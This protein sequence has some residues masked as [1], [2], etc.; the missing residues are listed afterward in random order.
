MS[1]PPLDVIEELFEQARRLPV[2]EQAAFVSA[3]SE[4]AA[5]RT[6]LSS[7][8]E[9]AEEAGPFLEGLAIHLRAAAALEDDEATSHVAPTSDLEPARLVNQYR[10]EELLGAGGMGVVYRAVDTRLGREV[11]L[12]FLPP[13]MSANERARRRLLAEARAA[14]ALNH[15]NVCALHEIG[16]DP[17][18]HVYIAMGYYGGRTLDRVL[19]EGPTSIDQ[20][21]RWAREVASALVAAHGR[22]IVHRDIKPGNILITGEDTV[23]LLDFGLAK[24]GDATVTDVGARL[25]TVAYMSPEQTR[26]EKVREETDLWSLGV[27]LYEMLTG[28]RPFDGGNAAV[29]L[30]AIRDGRPAPPS[31]LRDDLPADLEELVSGLLSPDPAARRRPFRA[32]LGEPEGVDGDVAASRAG[33]WRR[34]AL[35][36]GAAMALIAGGAYLLRRPAGPDLPEIRR[37]AVLPLA[38][39]THAPEQHYVVEGL[40]QAVLETL[41]R[42]RA[43]TVSSTDAVERYR[44]GARPPAEIARELGVDAVVEG[45][46]RMSGDSLRVEI[47]LLRAEDGARVWTGSFGGS[48]RGDILAL[49]SRVVAGIMAVTGAEG[50]AP[51]R[52]GAAG[53]EPRAERAYL[54]GLYEL[55]LHKN[56][57]PSDPTERNR[58]ARAALADFQEAVRIEPG[59]AAA[60]AQLASAYGW[61]ASG[62]PGSDSSFYWDS[63]KVE[64]TWALSLDESE[65]DAFSGLGFVLFNHEHDWV[66][67]ERAIVRAIELEPSSEHHWSYGLYLEAVGRYAESV[68]QY[69]EAEERDPMSRGLEGQVAHAYLC[70]GRYEE[71][72]RRY[73]Q[74]LQEYMRPAEAR[75]WLAYTYSRAGRHQEAID[76][77]QTAIALSDSAALDVA[78]L[79]YV[80]ARAGEVGKARAL[81]RWLDETDA[82]WDL[83]AFDAAAALAAVGEHERAV[84]AYQ[85]GIEQSWAASLYMRC[86][87]SYPELRDDPRIRRIEQGMHFPGGSSPLGQH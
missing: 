44:D 45:S 41:T 78:G 37:L 69:E 17:A 22:G 32:L 7:L 85:R 26:G 5:V 38:D 12:K 62:I 30:E 42:S 61:L 15:P 27:V 13:H 77:L 46:V 3:C 39:S 50:A 72:I 83:E 52:P 29:V 24:L 64:A 55:R 59:W 21:M 87:W 63:A 49:P 86:G 11:A 33:S 84:A 23:R 31:T 54:Q 53:R 28:R 40:H 67:A 14:A 66:Q 10:I 47:R 80:R 35:V 57:D 2:A 4:N 18:G 70:A 43:V 75:L 71:A 9:A 60:H 76:L 73:R 58:H 51:P 65:A 36:G 82:G 25:G 68:E 16:E 6:E 20:A 74:I 48:A 1:R 56:Q 34:P 19:E 8:L 81:I 79:A